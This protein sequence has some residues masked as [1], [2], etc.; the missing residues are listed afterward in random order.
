[1]VGLTYA[2]VPLYRMFCQATGFGGTVRE[3]RVVEEKLRA[4]RAS[5]DEQAEAACARREITVTFNADVSD[6]MPW[7]FSPTQRSV[8]ASVPTGQGSPASQPASPPWGGALVARPARAA[9]GAPAVP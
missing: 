3:G 9:A 1:M 8:K 6:G 4:R 7:R 2:A 5:R